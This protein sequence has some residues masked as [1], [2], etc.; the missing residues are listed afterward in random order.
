M[1]L[2]EQVKPRPQEKRE[3]PKSDSSAY[4]KSNL[5]KSVDRDE[6]TRKLIEEWL[7]SFEGAITRKMFD[8]QIKRLSYDAATA[9]Q[10]LQRAKGRRSIP[11]P[12]PEQKPSLQQP[13]YMQMAE[14]TF[15]AVY[16][17]KFKP[18]IKEAVKTLRELGEVY[19]LQ[20]EELILQF[21]SYDDKGTAPQMIDKAIEC[22]FLFV[23]DLEMPI[24]IEWHVHEAISRIGRRRE[25]MKKP[26][27]S[28][29]CRFNDVN[30]FFERF[31]IY[32]VG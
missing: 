8:Q 19:V 7:F 4:I 11:L 20:V 25:A 9:A 5:M 2:F 6:A 26:I 32:H 16:G 14:D 29:W 27:I 28:T 24:H 1:R 17:R 12:P 22:D 15:V 10:Q 3:P 30:D 18:A 23:V 31:K 13:L 21:K